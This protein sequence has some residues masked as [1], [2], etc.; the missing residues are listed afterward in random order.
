MKTLNKHQ[1]KAVADALAALNNVS[2]SVD[3][4]RFPGE[5]Q[6]VVFYC[7]GGVGV[8]TNG[9]SREEY[10]TIHDFLDAYGVT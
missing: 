10:D 3:E 7:R 5:A 9:R 2:A 6:A 8:S 4:I 1:A